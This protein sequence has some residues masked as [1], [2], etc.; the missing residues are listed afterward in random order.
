[1]SC[2]RCFALMASAEAC[3]ARYDAAAAEYDA[4]YAQEDAPE[5]PYASKYAA[6]AVMVRCCQQPRGAP[7]RLTRPPPPFLPQAPL[8]AELTAAAAVMSP[9]DRSTVLDLLA[10]VHVRLGVNAVETEENQEG[11]GHLVAALTW[12]TRHF[13]VHPRLVAFRPVSPVRGSALADAVEEGGGGE[14]GGKVEEGCAPPLP[15]PLSS[16]APL[17]AS[18]LA[19][20]H[21]LVLLYSGWDMH[22]R[23]LRALRAGKCVYRFLLALAAS[24]PAPDRSLQPDTLLSLDDSYTHVLFY[25][26]QVYGHLRCPRIAAGYVNRTLVR[27]L[28]GA[29]GGEGGRVEWARNAL[30][31]GAFHAGRRGWDD[32]A[33]CFAAGEGMLALACTPA[34]ICPEP[35]QRLRAEACAHWAGLYGCLLGEVRTGIEGAEGEG[36]GTPLPPPTNDFEEGGEAG[37]GEEA[38]DSLLDSGPSVRFPRGSQG[39]RMRGEGPDAIDAGDSDHEG[40]T[41]ALVGGAEGGRTLEAFVKRTAGAVQG[42]GGTAAASCGP[43]LL[44]VPGG[45]PGESV[46]GP[47]EGFP[48]GLPAPSPSLPL[49]RTLAAAA[50]SS[51]AAA[52]TFFLL[53]GYVSDH[54]H[55]TR[56][57]AGVYADWAACEVAPRRVAGLQAR[58]AAAVAPLLSSLSPTAYASLHRELSR[59][60]ASAFRACFEARLLAVLAEGRGGGGGGLTPGDEELV[61]APAQAAVA[62]Y[63]HYCSTFDDPRL[64][65]GGGPPSPGATPIASLDDA[66]ALLSAHIA[67]A[68]VLYTL[69][70]GGEVPPAIARLRYAES[71]MDALAGTFPGAFAQERVAVREMR[72]LLTQRVGLS[73]LC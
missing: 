47:G 43:A 48:Q 23:A 35:I 22:A 4:L 37:E 41:A 13:R 52:L 1:L 65:P 50:L 31:L 20:V 69:P 12:L 29:E 45:G 2:V 68:R 7:R 36:G 51:S 17:A 61:R 8:V 54:V 5:T 73:G 6:R 11:E 64:P 58:R 42:G 15:L 44:R 70:G 40:D 56:A 55:I 59:E 63:V 27:Q 32:A 62:C 33:L 21:F 66:H 19:A 30:R 28:A 10:R 67:I 16:A 38:G 26:A 57:V 14:G 24:T 60:A 49:A 39:G 46:A 72:A 9:A 34:A 71:M 3:T 53:D 25:Y 18:T